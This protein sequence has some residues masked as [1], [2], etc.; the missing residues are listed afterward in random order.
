MLQ[1]ILIGLFSSFFLSQIV[2]SQVDYSEKIRINLSASQTVWKKTDEIK[3]KLEIINLSNDEI[4]LNQVK[5]S[6][7]LTGENL[8]DSSESLLFWSPVV[9]QY[10]GTS[11]T[12]EE[13]EGRGVPDFETSILR[14]DGDEKEGYKINIRYLKWDLKESKAYPKKN[15]F[16]I[17]NSGNYKLVLSTTCENCKPMTSNEIDLSVN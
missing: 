4:V 8:G 1:K 2:F 16:D 5:T 13:V 7:L 6:F 3:L 14:L 12:W 10:L 15:L 11:N 9:L 17:V